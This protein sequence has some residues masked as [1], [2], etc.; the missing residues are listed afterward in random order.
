MQWSASFLPPQ[1]STFPLKNSIQSTPHRTAWTLLKHVPHKNKSYT[2]HTQSRNLWQFLASIFVAHSCNKLALKIELYS[3]C[4]N[5]L[6]RE[7]MCAQQHARCASFLYKSTYIT[8][9][10]SLLWQSGNQLACPALRLICKYTQFTEKTGAT[11]QTCIYAKQTNTKRN[12]H[13]AKKTTNTLWKAHHIEDPIK[14]VMV[15]WVASFDV[16]LPTVKDWFRRHQ[17]SK[18]APNRPD[19]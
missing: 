14:L 2:P 13:A 4:C 6:P 9:L 7:K 15:I 17:F 11:C 12:S 8:F 16:L 3:T 10:I 5:K 18:D 19:I 1:Q